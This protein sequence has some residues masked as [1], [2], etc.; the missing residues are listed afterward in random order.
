VLYAAADSAVHQTLT[1]PMGPVSG[2]VADAMFRPD[3]A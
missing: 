1:L 2:Y 3:A